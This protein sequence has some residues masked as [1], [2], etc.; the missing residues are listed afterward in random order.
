MQPRRAAQDA[1]AQSRADSREPLMM[2]SGAR[3]G[4]KRSQP[5]STPAPSD[6]PA[7]SPLNDEG[8]VGSG[9]QYVSPADKGED[10]DASSPPAAAHQPPTTQQTPT[11]P[12]APPEAS[13]MSPAAELRMVRQI[14]M[15]M[16]SPEIWSPTS[17]TS[18]RSCTLT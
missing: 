11:Q 17:Q 10:L 5:S 6:S 12:I 2:D 18:A 1:Y 4:S 7:P 14:L 16:A 9:I 13:A 15:A 3:A 8:A